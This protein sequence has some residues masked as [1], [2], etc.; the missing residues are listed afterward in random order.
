MEF[1][2]ED[3]IDYVRGHVSADVS[4][5]FSDDDIV[6]IVDAMMDYDFEHGLLD[7][8]ADVDD[9][10]PVDMA[11]VVGYLG[12]RFNKNGVTRFSIDD[13]SDIVKAELEFEDKMFDSNL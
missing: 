8:G 13:L 9:E 12:K 10:S 3:I 11:A 2:I 5:R 6:D 7:I 1:E 4:G